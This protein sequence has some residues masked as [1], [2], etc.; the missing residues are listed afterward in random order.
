MDN[1]TETFAEKRSDG[2]NIYHHSL[3]LRWIIVLVYT[4]S[5]DNELKLITLDVFLRQTCDKL[6][7]PDKL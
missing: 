3:T 2:V 1:G 5:V 4:K 7:Y 6:N